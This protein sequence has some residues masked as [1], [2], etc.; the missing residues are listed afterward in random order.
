MLRVLLYRLSTEVRGDEDGNLQESE[1][2]P[3]DEKCLFIGI[4][5][6]EAKSAE[7]GRLYLK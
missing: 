3:E 5:S 2:S 6:I 7:W 4:V 1:D